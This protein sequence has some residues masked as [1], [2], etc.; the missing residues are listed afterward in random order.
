MDGEFHTALT[1]A[2]HN[3]IPDIRRSPP[4]AKSMAPEVAPRGRSRLYGM[5]L[6]ALLHEQFCDGIISAIHFK[7]HIRKVPE[8][9]GGERAGIALAGTYLPVKPF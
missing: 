1:A 5:P 9:D 6:K 2:A 8:P 4:G 7:I 3:R